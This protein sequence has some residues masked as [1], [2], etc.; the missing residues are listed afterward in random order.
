MDPWVIADAIADLCNERLA[1]EQIGPL[2]LH[3]S[4]HGSHCLYFYFISR[5]SASCIKCSLM[6]FLVQ[7]SLELYMEVSVWNRTFLRLLSDIATLEKGLRDFPTGAVL[8]LTCTEL[9]FVQLL[10]KQIKVPHPVANALLYELRDSKAPRYM[11]SETA[12]QA[13]W[14]KMC[15]SCHM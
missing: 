4:L 9:P 11:Y 6:K 12:K 7:D 14:E 10:I 1:C 8:V 5:T 15:L 2:I 3:F 13:V